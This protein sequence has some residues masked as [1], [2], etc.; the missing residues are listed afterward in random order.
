MHAISVKQP[1]AE[2]IARGTKKIEYRS[3]KVAFRGPLLI[4]AS[5]GKQDERCREEGVD[6]EAVAYGAAVCVVDLREITGEPGNYEWHVRAPKRVEPVP[7]AGKAAIYHVEDAV[8]RYVRRRPR[9]A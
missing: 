7:V 6:P 1:W 2:L 9:P 4:V 8:I 3:W 5:K